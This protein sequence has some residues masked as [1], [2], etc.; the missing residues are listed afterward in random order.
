MSDPKGINYPE[1][2]T[3]RT[4]LAGVIAEIQAHPARREAVAR[5]E[6]WPEYV[7]DVVRRIRATEA[8]KGAGGSPT[9]PCG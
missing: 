1:D 4:H 5:A 9:V 6:R 3:L 7:A 2:Q 8:A